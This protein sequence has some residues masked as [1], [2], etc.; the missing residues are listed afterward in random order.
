MKELAQDGNAEMIGGVLP[1]KARVWLVGFRGAP[2]KN[3]RGEDAVE[4]GLYEG[5]AEEVFALFAFE[6][7]AERLLE[8]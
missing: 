1:A 7:D 6:G 4:E 8:G 2:P 5:G 3:P